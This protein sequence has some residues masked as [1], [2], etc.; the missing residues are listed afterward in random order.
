M[1]NAIFRLELRRNGGTL[2]DL[3]VVC[4]AGDFDVDRGVDTAAANAFDV[5]A[6]TLQSALEGLGTIGAG[7]IAVAEGK[8][9]FHHLNL[10]GGTTGDFTYYAGGNSIFISAPF[11][12]SSIQAAIVVATG[13]GTVSVTSLGGS[14]YL[15][16]FIGSLA[17]TAIGAVAISSD[18]TNGTGVVGTRLTIGGELS[19]WQLTF[20]G[21][22][23]NTDINDLSVTGN[24]LAYKA[25]TI[26]VDASVTDGAADVPSVVDNQIYTAAVA[27]ANEVQQVDL[28]G[29]TTGDFD[30][31]G[32]S[33]SANVIVTG[34]GAVDEVTIQAACDTI[35]GSGNTT[36]ASLGG[37]L[38]S[39]TF[40]NAFA[41]T[42]VA[43]MTVTNN[44]TDGTPVVTTTTQ[45]NAGTHQVDHCTVSP[46]P[47][48]GAMEYA[49]QALGWNT[50]ASTLTITGGTASGAPSSGL[51]T[52]TW[53]SYSV[54]TPKGVGA[55]TLKETGEYQVATVSLTDAPTEG[56]VVITIGGTPYS[57]FDFNA[58]AATVTTAIGGSGWTASGTAPNWTITNGTRATNTTL[59]AAEV[60][61]NPLR[62]A[63]DIVLVEVQA[64]TPVG[65][66]AF[67]N[68]YGS[69][70]NV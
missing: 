42:N 5:S 13:S 15:V 21:D 49:G 24:A 61:A 43:E 22:L 63:A 66:F 27:Q 62:K 59:T 56:K 26:T 29:A 47:D 2:D 23:A 64:G 58:D 18:S 1:A 45:G 37:D 32:N 68:L 40:G 41:N 14:E 11:S 25:D 57:E 7:N 3:P 60:G 52:F 53:D 16:E 67:W 8:N 46:V 36:V 17:G 54:E 33:T 69:C 51:I 44:S 31:N 34:V 20:Q 9:E 28:G 65:G 38:F 6:A 10:G 4:E 19:Y 39:V 35:W 30:L 70:A 12:A 50:N 55:D 48:S